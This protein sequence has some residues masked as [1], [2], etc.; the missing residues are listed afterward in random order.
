V[1]ATG[2]PQRA[3]VLYQVQSQAFSPNRPDTGANMQVLH[4]L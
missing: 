2:T 1:G 4:Q 3:L